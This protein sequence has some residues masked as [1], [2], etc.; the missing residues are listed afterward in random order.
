MGKSY[1]GDDS[2]IIFDFEFFGTL[3]EWQSR[4]RKNHWHFFNLVTIRPPASLPLQKIYEFMM[5]RSRITC[6]SYDHH[7]SQ[8]TTIHQNLPPVLFNRI[9]DLLETIGTRSYWRFRF[10]VFKLKLKKLCHGWVHVTLIMACC[11]PSK[12]NAMRVGLDCPLRWRLIS[13]PCP[14]RRHFRI[15][16]NQPFRIP[17]S[18]RHGTWRV[19]R[20][21][22]SLFGQIT[23]R[24]ILTENDPFW[25]RTIHSDR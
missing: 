16:W 20:L 4:R 21:I 24:F 18:I 22:C 5:E 12:C 10:Q 8:F 25:Q 7:A 11:I 6:P 15:R 2:L 14:L 3:F 13:F 17:K 9:N 23:L 1:E 19:A